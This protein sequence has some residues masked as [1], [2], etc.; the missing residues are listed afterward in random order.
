MINNPIASDD[1]SVQSQ[2]N[3]DDIILR[4][5]AT[6][7]TT[8]AVAGAPNVSEGRW[9]AA[10]AA[11]LSEKLAIANEKLEKAETERETI[12]SELRTTKRTSE[13]QSERIEKL[14]KAEK[15]LTKEVGEKSEMLLS[16]QD[17]RRRQN[18][19]LLKAQMAV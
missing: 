12:A 13:A 1:I 14:K 5:R 2:E 4:A 11:K 7:A 3:S 18:S 15:M 17:E 6:A 10:A 8:T 16:M 19:S 9:E